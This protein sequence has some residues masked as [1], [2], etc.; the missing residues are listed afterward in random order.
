MS[1]DNPNTTDDP[2]DE[3]TDETDLEERVEQ[4][5]RDAVQD[6]D[7]PITMMR[8]FL[9][10]LAGHDASDV[11]SVDDLPPLPVA[12]SEA[13]DYV[14]GLEDEIEELNA[15]I[16][17]VEQTANSA[18]GVAQSASKGAAPD[19]GGLSKTAKARNAA[20]NELVKRALLDRSTS[21][22]GSV[23]VGDVQK[24]LKPGTDVAYQTV[25]DAFGDL[26]ETWPA[27]VEGENQDGNRALKVKTS[28][29][30]KDLVGAVEADLDRDDLTKK[31]ISRTGNGGA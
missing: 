4:L 24:M 20:R 17:S 1:T 19:G 16:E 8:R 28:K 26:V 25:K 9:R 31:L 10:R 22:G 15:K 13:A 11:E 18:L 23:T 6:T 14:E 3:Q 30:S 5:E 29:L 27:F 21:S 7:L 12:M 2:T